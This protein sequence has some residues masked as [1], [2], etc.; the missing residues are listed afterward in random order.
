MSNPKLLAC[1]FCGAMPGSFFG[2]AVAEVHHTEKCYLS[3]NQG[4]SLGSVRA[5]NRR[6]RP[7]SPH[8]KPGKG[9]KA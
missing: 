1:P 6:A 2:W 4:I 9:G 3:D 7:A 5:W 8:G